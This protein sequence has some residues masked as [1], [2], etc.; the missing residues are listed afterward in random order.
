AVMVRAVS[1]TA[2]HLSLTPPKPLQAAFYGAFWLLVA[3]LEGPIFLVLL[4]AFAFAFRRAWK[5]WF[6]M[7]HGRQPEAFSKQSLADLAPSP[8]QVLVARVV[9]VVVAIGA[10]F[11]RIDDLTVLLFNLYL[12]PLIPWITYWMQSQI[13]ISLVSLRAL[14]SGRWRPRRV[15]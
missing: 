10:D 5:Q 13:V 1:E 9:I 6:G 4:L 3:L 2:I 12:P 11:T 8:R 14:V 15:E 7:I